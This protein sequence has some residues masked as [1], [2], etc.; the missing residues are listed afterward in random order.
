ECEALGT[1]NGS[2]YA[3]ESIFTR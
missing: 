3:A 1:D 2:D